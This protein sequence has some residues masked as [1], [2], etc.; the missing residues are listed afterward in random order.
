MADKEW[1]VKELTEALKRF[2]SDAKVTTKWGQTVQEQL[3][4]RNTSRLGAR[5]TRCQCS[6]T[7]RFV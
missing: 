1:T 7:D 3:E 6:W 5:T 2:P 4:K